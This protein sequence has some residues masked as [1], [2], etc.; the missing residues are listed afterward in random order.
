MWIELAEAD[1]PR[2]V[3]LLCDECGVLFQGERS[4]DRRTYWRLAN[5]AG[6]A[7]V[8]RAPERHICANC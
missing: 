2:R 4:E 8:A 7:R 1:A 5:I 6:W 3:D